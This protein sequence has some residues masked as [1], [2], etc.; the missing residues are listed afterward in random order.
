MNLEHEADAYAE[1]DFAD[2][3]AAF[4]ERLLEVVGPVD[5]AIAAMGE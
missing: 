4:V 5:Q 2:V 1:T 3:N